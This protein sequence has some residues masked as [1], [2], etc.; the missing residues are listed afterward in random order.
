MW[1]GDL[2]GVREGNCDQNVLYERR[3]KKKKKHFLN[4]HTKPN[5]SK[6]KQANNFP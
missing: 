6:T 4:I 3:I 2:G 1:E 5:Q